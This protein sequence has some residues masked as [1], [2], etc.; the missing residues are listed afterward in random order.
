MSENVQITND[1]MPEAAR[2]EN[3]TR[4]E[5]KELEERERLQFRRL[6]SLS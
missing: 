5:L 6:L 4:R 1:I 2:L 3:L